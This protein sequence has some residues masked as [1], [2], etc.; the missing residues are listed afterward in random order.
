MA[1]EQSPCANDA[2]MWAMIFWL[3]AF[4]ATFPTDYISSPHS[5]ASESISN[6]GFLC[7]PLVNYMENPPYVKLKLYVNNILI[8]YHN[9]GFT[10]NII[11]LITIWKITVYG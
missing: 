9:L 10:N 5:E 2:T 1:I 7:Y 11:I 6:L 8:T 4:I 3:L